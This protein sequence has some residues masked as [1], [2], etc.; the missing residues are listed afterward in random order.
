LCMP[1]YKSLHNLLNGL[2]QAAIQWDYKELDLNARIH[3]IA[4]SNDYSRCVC[5]SVCG[6]E[7]K[8]ASE[9]PAKVTPSRRAWPVVFRL[10]VPFEKK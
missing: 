10:L 5:V 2:L 8:L 9:Y 7:A 3:G 4:W 6:G 1:L